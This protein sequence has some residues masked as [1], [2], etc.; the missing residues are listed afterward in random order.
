M[1]GPNGGLVRSGAGSDARFVASAA[2]LTSEWVVGRR[3]RFTAI[4]THFSP[5]TF[6][7]ETGPAEPIDFVELTA[8]FRF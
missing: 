3:W 4:Y 6:L 8:R 5:E 1:Y 7:Q 2:S